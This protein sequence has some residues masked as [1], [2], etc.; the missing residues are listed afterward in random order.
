MHV[1]S[2]DIRP[3]SMLDPRPASAS[4]YWGGALFTVA[5]HGLLPVAIALVM[6]A[7][8]SA[9][10]DQTSQPI[11][12]E[13]V[14]EA[15]FVKLGKPPD[16]K[17]LPDRIVPRKQTAPDEA[18]VVSK[19]PTDPPVKPDAGPR[20][21]RPEPDDLL[22]L[23]D[24]AQ[25]FAEIAE[26]NDV[27]DPNGIEGADNSVSQAGDL[28]VGQLYMFFKRGWTIPTTL[29]DTSKLVAS[30]DVEI[31]RDLKVG[32]FSIVRSSGEPMF[33]QSV[34][35]RLQQLRTDG[36]TVPEPPAEVADK[37]IGRTLGLNFKGDKK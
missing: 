14:V 10:G 26:E 23:G 15:R 24:R 18:T 32:E 34:E 33:D 12:D 20:P 28:Y 35:D 8:S 27:G 7:L 31:T 25:A 29:G 30:V 5:A 16:P 1:Q 6:S 21:E 4:V 13:H 17:K 2:R 11:R 22:R 19:N 3:P 9:L 36:A 37:F